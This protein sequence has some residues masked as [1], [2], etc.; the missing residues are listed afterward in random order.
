MPNDNNEKEQ[1]NNGTVLTHKGFPT[2]Q[3]LDKDFDLD[4]PNSYANRF[5]S[6]H[7]KNIANQF[8]TTKESLDINPKLP[9]TYKE[10][11]RIVNR[12]KLEFNRIN[13]QLNQTGKAKAY[14]WGWV[15][16]A[17]ETKLIEYSVETVLA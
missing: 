1:G 6:E 2:S 7:G 9:M 16:A 11:T 4:D 12:C 17:R 3:E 8:F 15:V 14:I 10:K 5:K 13:G